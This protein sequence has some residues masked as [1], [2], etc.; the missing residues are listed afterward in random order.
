[1]TRF[2][3]EYKTV[4]ITLEPYGDDPQSLL[5]GPTI[6]K[7]ANRWAS[8]GWRTV[9]VIPSKGVGYADCIL[10]ERKTLEPPVEPKPVERRSFRSWRK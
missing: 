3:Y 7:A 2:Y 9:A 1:M 6:E 8:L 5:T 10:V 4:N